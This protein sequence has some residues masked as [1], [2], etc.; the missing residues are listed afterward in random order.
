VVAVFLVQSAQW[1]PSFT[2]PFPL[3]VLFSAP[4][5]STGTCKVRGIVPVSKLWGLRTY[6]RSLEH[7]H[8]P[9]HGLGWSRVPYP[10]HQL[11][12]MEQ[13]HD[14]QDPGLL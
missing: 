5:L 11:H 8:L 1:V 10:M 13:Q 6:F 2:Q 4:F 12:R 7:W 3:L 9:V 14:H